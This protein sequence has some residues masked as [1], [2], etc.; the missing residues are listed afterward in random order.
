M[1]LKDIK[2]KD[3][4]DMDLKKELHQGLN[5][6]SNYLTKDRSSMT[7][8]TWFL[9]GTA[10]GAAATYLFDPTEGS[11]RRSKIWGSANDLKD[12]A[13]KLGRDLTTIGKDF[14]DKASNTTTKTANRVKSKVDAT[15]D[16]VSAEAGRH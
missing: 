1:Q 8:L 14:A 12:Q 4:A 10:V 16:R 7:R 5:K 2:L 6:V 9:V 3:V 15:T 11:K 13:M